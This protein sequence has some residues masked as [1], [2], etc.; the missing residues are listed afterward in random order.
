[1]KARIEIQSMVH[2]FYFARSKAHA[3]VAYFSCD[4]LLPD[5][6][7]GYPNYFRFC[8]SVSPLHSYVEGRRSHEG[9]Y[10]IPIKSKANL[11]LII[12]YVKI[13]NYDA[14]F[15]PSKANRLQHSPLSFFFLF[16]T[17]RLCNE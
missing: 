11:T 3:Y 6:K 14:S 12:S 15:S 1:M 17:V 4:S 10:F 7:R 13:L 8:N 9:T 5:R 2:A 16:F